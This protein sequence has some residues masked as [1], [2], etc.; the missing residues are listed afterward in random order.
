MTFDDG[1]LAKLKAE[2]TNKR[3]F[4]VCVLPTDRKTDYLGDS[5][6]D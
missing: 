3:E 5:K 6:W 1:L 4:G 2:E